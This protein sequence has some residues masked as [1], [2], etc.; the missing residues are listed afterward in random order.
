[1]DMGGRECLCVVI[2]V[3]LGYDTDGRNTSTKG[4]LQSLEIG[5]TASENSHFSLWGS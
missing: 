1:M 3:E 4:V 5:M 2:H